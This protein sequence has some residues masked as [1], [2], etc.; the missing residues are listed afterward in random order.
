MDNFYG[1]IEYYSQLV[2]LLNVDL[3]YS[4]WYTHENPVLTPNPELDI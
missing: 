3:P 1:A 4:T 2:L